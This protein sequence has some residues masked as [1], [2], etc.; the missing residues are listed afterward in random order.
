[1]GAQQNECEVLPLNKIEVFT[2]RQVAQYSARGFRVKYYPRSARMFM[3]RDV[4][5]P[6][7]D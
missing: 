3:V 7:N 5:A 6:A 1:M 2:V 4:T